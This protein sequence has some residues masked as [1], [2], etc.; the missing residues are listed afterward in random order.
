MTMITNAVE[1]RYR[2]GFMSI[3]SALQLAANAIASILAGW[4]VTRDPAGHLLGLPMV[5]YIATGFFIL[6]LLFAIE[7]RAVAPHV[8]SHAKKHVAPPPPPEIAAA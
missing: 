4:F 1:A 7:L 5:S 3:I 2:G 6:T 8:A